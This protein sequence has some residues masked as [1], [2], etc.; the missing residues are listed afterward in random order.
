MSNKESRQGQQPPPKELKR[1][2]GFLD[3]TFLSL[4]GQSP[5]LSI[6]L[7]GTVSIIEAGLFGPIVILLGTLLVLLNG[8][9]VYELSKR[10]TKAGGYYT[11]AFYS[12]TRRL[13][14]ETGWVYLLYSVAYGSAYILGAGY[15]M[16]SV[17]GIS[18]WI[19]V[20]VVLGLGSALVLSGI[21]PSSKYAMF[22]SILE[23]ALMTT[24][25][26]FFLHSTGFRF[27]NPF[28]KIPSFGDI[29][30]GILFGSSIPTGYGS[31]TP[32]AGEVKDP[33]RTVSRAIVTVILIG[34]L[35]AAFDVYAIA[36][37][38]SFY[39]L[40]PA[41]VNIVSLIESRF[42]VVT[43]ALVIFGAM[44]DSILA[45]LAYMT[46][47]SRTIFA[48][49]SN[50][51]FPEKLSQLKNYKPTNA[52]LITIALF[53]G[54]TVLSLFSLMQAFEAFLVVSSI[55]LFANL[56]IHLAADSSLFKISLKRASRRRTEIA[57]AIGGAI[58]T[59][60]D[61]V[62]SIGN[63]SYTM[64]YVFFAWIIIGFLIA[65]VEDMA[66]QEQNEAEAEEKHRSRS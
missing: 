64:V 20:L 27:Y 15:V 6:L 22:A 24:L 18:P 30:L 25:A 37:H 10:F 59:I 12:L 66:K 48:M 21:K 52:I 1:D 61:L 9:A 42:G 39:G 7:Y 33:K 3:L 2:I 13:G 45:T 8:L 36:D 5:F 28:S 54:I 38:L 23:I 43:F 11:Y 53:F 26:I 46:A 60:I 56:F 34:G 35:L 41:N 47:T 14:F 44:N 58:F 55:S 49:A 50:G 19:I 63:T 17:L 29:A 16:S 57:L 31:I 65:E 51:L 32:N 40:N 62:T 4:G